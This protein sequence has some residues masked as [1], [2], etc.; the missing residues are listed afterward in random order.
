MANAGAY[1]VLFKGDVANSRID[2]ILA[3]LTTEGVTIKNRY[4]L[5]TFKGFAATLTDDQLTKVLNLEE[6]DL[7]E[8][9]GEITA[10]ASKSTKLGN[11]K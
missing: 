5:G 2:E 4:N 9:D 3:G 1:V 8:P 10:F 7:F 6:V 11:K